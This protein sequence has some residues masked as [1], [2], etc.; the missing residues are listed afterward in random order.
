MPMMPFL[1]GG[2]PT[3]QSSPLVG[4]DGSNVTV[5]NG[6]GASNGPGPAH[7]PGSSNVESTSANSKPGAIINKPSAT[8]SSVGNNHV[9]LS[10]HLSNMQ[11]NLF[12]VS[13]TSHQSEL[14]ELPFYDN[15]LTAPR[16]KAFGLYAIISAPVHES[17]KRAVLFMDSGS[18]TS[19]FLESSIEKLNARVLAHGNI[20]MS[21]LH[22]T[23]SHKEVFQLP[24]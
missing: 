4:H 9:D 10:S 3:P 14:E 19:L 11:V 15:I 21:T 20:K 12:Q 24:G 5:S 16:G 8:K 18:D 1:Y 13:E 6:P 7:E 23:G 17:K 22:G 2:Y